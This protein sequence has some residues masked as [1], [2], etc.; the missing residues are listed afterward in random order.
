MI[1]RLL[2]NGEVMKMR[3]CYGKNFNSIIKF[4]Y[5]NLGCSDIGRPMFSTAL[6]RRMVVQLTQ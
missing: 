6:R 4:L 5:L 1:M 3:Q 2:P